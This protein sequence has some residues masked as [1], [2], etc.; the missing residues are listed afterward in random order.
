MDILKEEYIR[1]RL[2]E[3]LIQKPALYKIPQEVIEKKKEE[4]N[5]EF[6][7]EKHKILNITKIN[8]MNKKN[9]MKIF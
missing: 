7:K 2:Q 9:N 1:K 4:F 3:W 6:L 5:L 8:N